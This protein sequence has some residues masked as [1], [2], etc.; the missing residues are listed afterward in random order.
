MKKTTNA[1]HECR[2]SR[3]TAATLLKKKFY[4]KRL[5]LEEDKDSGRVYVNVVV[6][7]YV[8]IGLQSACCISLPPLIASFI[9]L[10]LVRVFLGQKKSTARNW[11]NL[12]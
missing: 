11:A 7:L 3:D 2:G 12:L 10:T 9:H 6:R 1:T 5:F 8:K 4:L